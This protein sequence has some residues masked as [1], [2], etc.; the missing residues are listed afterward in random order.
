MLTSIDCKIRER[1]ALGSHLK[2][3]HLDRIQCLQWRKANGEDTIKQKYH[4]N[5]STAGGFRTG[6][7]LDL[8]GDKETNPDQG[9]TDVGEEQKRST[10][11][12]IHE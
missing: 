3:Q 6:V 1:H 8:G 9:A 2:A 11:D 4:R 10:T 12:S 7:L 5:E